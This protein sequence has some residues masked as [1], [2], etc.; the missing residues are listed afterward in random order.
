MILRQMK[1]FHFV[2]TSFCLD[3][4]HERL[5]LRT[6]PGVQV[7]D[8]SQHQREI[9]KSRLFLRAPARGADV[10][11]ARYLLFRRLAHQVAPAS[12]LACHAAVYTHSDV[13]RGEAVPCPQLA[14][15]PVVES[16]SRSQTAQC[17]CRSLVVSFR[18][19]FGFSAFSQLEQFSASGTEA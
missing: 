1:E 8:H 3:N 13:A 4:L 12:E 5:L 16:M 2:R 17:S 14:S 7:R 18:C 11:H 19:D 10:E 15:R 6:G 9:L